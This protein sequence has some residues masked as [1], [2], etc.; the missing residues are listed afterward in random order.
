MAVGIIGGGGAMPLEV[1]LRSGAAL[2]LLYSWMKIGSDSIKRRG[3]PPGPPGWP[4]VGNMFDLG[5]SPHQTFYKLRAEYGPVLWLKLG[6]VNTMVIQSA[7]SAAE[8]FKNHDLSFSDRKA[9]ESLTALGYN[10]SALAVC[11]YGAYW[12]RLRRLYTIELFA[13]KRIQESAPLRE[14]CIDKMV[15]WI[16]EDSITSRA[17]GG[18]GEVKLV[19][20][21]F[22]MAFNMVGNL[23]FSRDLLQMQSNEGDEFFEAM[24][25]FMEWAMKPNVADFFPFLKWLDPQRIKRN[26]ARDMGRC[27]KIITGLVDERVQEKQLGRDDVKND[28]LDVLLAYESDGKEGPH[29]LSESTVNIIILEMFFGGSETTTST[30]EWVMTELLRNP[31][32]MKKVKD[33]LDQAVG[34]NVKVKESD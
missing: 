8:L 5:T 25:K 14:K 28:F 12:R 27:M 30:I 1:G 15:R 29:K 11:E 21:L 33:E 22:L 3:R 17:Q 9:T 18:S 31:R 23:M 20:Y 32:S 10:E 26:M 24:N 2:L 19:K 6:F 34:P 4:I 13:S 7:Y 16:E